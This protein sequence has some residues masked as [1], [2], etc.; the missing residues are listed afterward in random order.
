MPNRTD[1]RRGKVLWALFITQGHWIHRR[2]ETISFIGAQRTRRQM[3][4]DYEVPPRYVSAFQASGNAA[5][6]IPLGL[7]PHAPHRAFDLRDESGSSLPLLDHQENIDRTVEMLLGGS[8]S[9]GFRVDDE[10]AENLRH[11]AR[12]YDSGADAVTAGL[13]SRADKSLTED[14]ANRRCSFLTRVIEVLDR[15]SLLLADAGAADRRR[16]VKLAYDTEPKLKASTA[17]R[18][19]WQVALLQF[20]APAIPLC[21]SYHFEL[22][23][24]T[25]LTIGHKAALEKTSREHVASLPSNESRIH[26]SETVAHLTAID[27]ESTGAD[28]YLAEVSLA[29]DSDGLVRSAFYASAFCAVLL[30]IG[31]LFAHRLAPMT[32]AGK[33]S[34]SN[35]AAVT[36]LLALPALL[37]ALL[38]RAGEHTLVSRLLTGVRALLVGVAVSLVVAGGTV[39][40]G[41]SETIIRTVW[42]VLA[43]ACALVALVLLRARR[44]ITIGAHLRDTERTLRSSATVRLVVGEPTGTESVLTVESAF[45]QFFLPSD[46]GRDWVRDRA[47]D[48]L[49]QLE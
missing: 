4:L 13:I 18:L 17:T 11:V 23:A 2:V 44:A 36:I 12:N 21:A 6:P 1:S 10:L 46:I 49:L 7:W 9:L 27:V 28:R 40:L 33:P 3:S 37:T 5:I 8:E 43:V 47:N 48:A 34:S 26:L 25:G 30:A 16:I 29:P 41:F 38:S 45:A 42:G 24:P 20:D 35:S 39:A 32:I 22:A 19:G 31:A 15:N 14:E